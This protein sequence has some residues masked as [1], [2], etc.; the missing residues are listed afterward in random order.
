MEGRHSNIPNK[1][2]VKDKRDDSPRPPRYTLKQ[3]HKQTRRVSDSGTKQWIELIA[4]FG[5]CD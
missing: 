3:S 2:S 1:G 4:T 5:K